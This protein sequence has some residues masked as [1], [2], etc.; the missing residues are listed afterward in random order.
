MELIR[1][2]SSARLKKEA[3]A[4]LDVINLSF[5]SEIARGWEEVFV[6]SIIDLLST[7][8]VSTPAASLPPPFLNTPAYCYGSLIRT[9][10]IFYAVIV[11]YSK[12]NRC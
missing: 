3:V 12:R 10:A 2:D 9:V 4:L 11:R 6:V 8:S 1:T 7:H 5:D